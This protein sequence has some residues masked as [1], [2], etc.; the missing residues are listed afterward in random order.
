[1]S[2]TSRSPDEQGG[3]GGLR[4]A[5]RRDFP[6]FGVYAALTL[7]VTYP[8]PFKLASSFYG[9][10]E[11][12]LYFQ[13]SFW[14]LARGGGG[15]VLDKVPLLG[16]PGALD[17][18]YV[19]REMAVYAP[20]KIL[21]WLLGE[22][23]AYN[24][25]IL[26][27]FLLAGVFMYYLVLYLT[28][29][30]P[31]AFLSGLAFAFCPYH[32]MH[33]MVH[34]NLAGIQWLPLYCLCLFKFV[35]KRSW[36]YAA[37]AGVA[38]CAFTLTNYHYGVFAAI[39]TFVFLATRFV[40]IHRAHRGKRISFP[41]RDLIMK[42]A[43][44]LLIIIVTVGPFALHMLSGSVSE[45][46]VER[47]HESEL[48]RFSARP[49]DYVLPTAGNPLLGRF[50]RGFIYDHMH[51]SFEYEASNYLGLVI[52]LLAIPALIWLFRFSFKGGGSGS[53]GED[54]EGD[55]ETASPGGQ[56]VGATPEG[57]ERFNPREGTG[58]AQVL[59]SC[60]AGLLLFFFLSLPPYFSVGN[61]RI[62]LPSYLLHKALPMVRSYSRFGLMVMFCTV[63]LAAYGVVILLGR[64]RE[65][66]REALLV[67]L[68]AVLIL[69][70]FIIIPPFR[71]TET[72]PDA[73]IN[74]WLAE[75][76]MAGGIACYPMDVL[77]WYKHEHLFS[78]TVHGKKMINTCGWSLENPVG[79]DSRYQYVI[80]VLHPYTPRVLAALGIEKAI[81][82][83]SY[84]RDAVAQMAPGAESLE[85]PVALIPPGYRLTETFANGLALEVTAEPAT[86]IPRFLEGFS[87]PWLV[88][89]AYYRQQCVGS[90]EINI[91]NVGDREQVASLGLDVIATDCD[92][93]L[94]LEVNGRLV[95]EWEL[96]KGRDRGVTTGEIEFE[97]GDNDVELIVRRSGDDAIPGREAGVFMSGF[98][99]R[100]G[101]VL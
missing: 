95:G 12:P 93:L 18:S 8:V 51:G 96:E 4:G 86:L 40:I 69:L 41:P 66:K 65:R 78:Q 27:S 39:F 75:Q 73:P 90:G 7:I 54:D 83:P 99:I 67:A 87:G 50:T 89:N 34:V 28:G 17:L 68:L 25:L 44:I 16:Y 23:V 85:F 52:M 71:Y 48:I 2:D 92:A 94:G 15:W 26:G 46:L 14:Y 53:D 37:G 56:P 77:G 38:F 59:I 30:R 80:D 81:V 20:G 82:I 10:P 43:L 79:V 31:A 33:A 35:E 97:P 24:L 60:L 1:M 42:V 72:K 63:I 5:I 61:T 57:R 84:W 100:T 13:W 101:E 21:T 76:E 36:G 3:R 91:V 74:T 58:R 55:K 11:D 47:A 64:V 22:T 6:F 45:S 49:W 9:L 62:Y 70:D 19:P 98:Y 32:L 29:S 88:N